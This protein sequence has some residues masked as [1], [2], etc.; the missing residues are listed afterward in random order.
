[1][2]KLDP[3]EQLQFLSKK[4]QKIS[5]GIYRDQALY[6]QV[7]RKCLLKSV[8]K[9][10]FL[11]ITDRNKNPLNELSSQQKKALQLKI[12]ELVNRSNSLLTVE[13]LMDLARQIEEEKQLKR[14]YA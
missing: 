6:L 13:Q 9:V 5:P 12:D 1:M 3:S 10:I 11:L 4:C 8:R 7:L 2:N 14:D